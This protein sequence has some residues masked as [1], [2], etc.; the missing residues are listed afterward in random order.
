M[1][2]LPTKVLYIA[3]V[4]LRILAARDET[5][6]SLPRRCCIILEPPPPHAKLTTPGGSPRPAAPVEAF[7][8]AGA[9]P[10]CA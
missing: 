9:P 8:D 7:P 6:A 4:L 5:L 3:L 1:G 10:P 2:D